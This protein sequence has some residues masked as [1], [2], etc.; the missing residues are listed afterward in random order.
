MA[1][2]CLGVA[3]SSCPWYYE[4]AVDASLLKFNICCK[5]RFCYPGTVPTCILHTD[6]LG[7]SVT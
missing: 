5:C 1:Q 6:I 4:H 3:G 7:M 2:A